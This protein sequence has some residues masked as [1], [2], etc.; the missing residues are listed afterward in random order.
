MPDP[1]N[2][3]AAAGRDG[4]ATQLR[5]LEEFIARTE[6]EGEELPAEAVEMIARLREIVRALDGLTSSMGGP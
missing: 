2:D 1:I 4:L 3:A 5:Q 6:A